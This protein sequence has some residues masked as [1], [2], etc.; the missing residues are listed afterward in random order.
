[1]EYML[2]FEKV[3]AQ[4]KKEAKGTQKLLE[5]ICE[6]LDVRE[7]LEA[8]EAQ[9]QEKEGENLESKWQASQIYRKLYCLSFGILGCPQTTR[10]QCR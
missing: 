5:D 7:R 6:P 2:D 4:A 3:L 1:M 9:I 8:Q 10:E